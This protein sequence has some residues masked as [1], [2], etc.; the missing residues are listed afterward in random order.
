MAFLAKEESKEENGVKRAAA[1]EAGKGGG[2]L[3][4]SDGSKEMASQRNLDA[5]TG[6]MNIP[7]SG[8]QRPRLW[9]GDLYVEAKVQ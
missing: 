3:A 6:K 7:L 2:V 4:C 8:G 1:E 9:G 5:E